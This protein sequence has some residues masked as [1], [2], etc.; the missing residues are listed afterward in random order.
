VP[1]IQALPRGQRSAGYWHSGC[2][3]AQTY[4]HVLLPHGLPHHHAAAHLAK[5]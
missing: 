2:T 5:R 4:R 1:G 3:E